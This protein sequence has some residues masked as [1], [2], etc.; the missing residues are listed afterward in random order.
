MQR[1]K[2]KLHKY[3]TERR[4]AAGT[5]PGTIVIDPEAPNPV[6]TVL[7]YGS[8][9]FHEHK[10]EDVG[11]IQE[12]LGEWPVTW[13]NVD[14]LGD[15]KTIRDIG[16]IFGLHGL[17]LEDVVH[18]HQRPK[19]EFYEDHFFI[20]ARM[21]EF[22]FAAGE[23]NNEQISIFLGKNYV[24][25]FQENPG[26]CFDPVRDRIRKSKGRMRDYGADHLAYA[27]L[28]AVIDAYFPILE[29][30]GDHLED[31]ET[32]TLT[33]ADART[34]S[35]INDVKQA[36]ITLR[37]SAWPLRELSNTLIRD[38]SDL[39]TPETRIY[40][41]DCYDHAVGIIEL[42]E[43]YREVCSGL[44]D[45]YLS[46]VS[47]KMNEIMKVLTMI[48]T[49]FIPITFFAGIYGMNFNTDKSP[50]NMPELNWYMGYPFFWAV[51]LAVS[52]FML[53]FF[54]R[55]KWL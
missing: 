47:N 48:A 12:H 37:R 2:L 43:S 46:S 38:T 27:L 44:M 51:T 13:V 14:G 7:A 30:M 34:V 22:D 11:E 54:R 24:L 32:E 53:L 52:I 9:S 41:R 21:A 3:D 26:D 31:L 19:A 55:K 16:E 18:T 17:A 15:E 36:L 45:M 10:I 6:V 33:K 35:A 49:I 29:D 5:A 40:L 50:L 42:I 28:D 1:I 4:H 39:I 23:L 8:G 25:T 20:V